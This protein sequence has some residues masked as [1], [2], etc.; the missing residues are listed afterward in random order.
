MDIILKLGLE[1]EAILSKFELFGDVFRD[2]KF[3]GGEIQFLYTIL[4]T[5]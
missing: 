1:F 5:L 2:L 4:P 3:V